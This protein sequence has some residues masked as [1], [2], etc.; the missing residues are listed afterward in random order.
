MRWR[1]LAAIAVAAVLAAPPAATRAQQPAAPGVLDETV[2]PGA[3]YDKAEFRFWMPPAAAAAR[4]IVVLV[5][6]SNGDGRSMA[7]DAFWQ[8]FATRHS[9]ALVAC[10]FTDKPHEQAFIEHYVN[11]SQGSGQALLEAI[12]R[13]AERSKHPE[14]TTVPFYMWGMSAGGQFNYEFVVWKPERVAAFVVNKGGIYYTAL[15]P[16][17]AR[18]VPGLL[19]I[20]ETDLAF[21]NDTITGLFAVNRR[22]GARWALT[23]EPGLA[24]VVGRS[25][26]LGAMLF[27]EVPPLKP[28]DTPAG[29]IGDLKAQTFKP[30]AEAGALSVP[31]AWLATGRLARGWQSVVSGKPFN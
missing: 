5:P 16:K 30:A 19:F 18:D 13:F 23:R 28:L 22:A 10:R 26:E 20:G 17:A 11:V 14:L 12:D 31:T 24:H 6:G 21:R 4:A 29:F 8:E 7:T 3:N 2:P 15:A 27:E 9:L 1:V 25:R